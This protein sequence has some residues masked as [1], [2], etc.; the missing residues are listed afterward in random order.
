M[1]ADCGGR[2]PNC[3]E[4]EMDGARC[5]Y[6]GH[7]EYDCEMPDCERCARPQ[8]ERIESA[9]G[10]ELLIL[11]ALDVAYQ[12]GKM[13]YLHYSPARDATEARLSALSWLRALRARQDKGAEAREAQR[14]SEGVMN[15]V[16]GAFDC[17][18]VPDSTW[19]ELSGQIY[20][21]AL[22]SL[23]H[24]VSNNMQVAEADLAAFKRIASIIERHNG[25][26]SEKVDDARLIARERIGALSTIRTTPQEQDHA[27]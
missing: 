7:H 6:C 27:K 3:G 25:R 16:H 17:D 9:E 24:P 12:A 23:S 2:C 1:D 19:E 13:E 14:F 8:A 10:H 4:D 26:Q 22:A 18:G 20:D 5:Y 11:E 21:L 15:L